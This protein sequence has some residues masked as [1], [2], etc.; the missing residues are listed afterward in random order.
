MTRKKATGCV[1]AGMGR[2]SR[3]TGTSHLMKKGDEGPAT[4]VAV[5]GAQRKEVFPDR[6]LPNK[7]RLPK[8][9]LRD[10]EFL[11]CD[12]KQVNRIVVKRPVSAIECEE[13]SMRSLDSF[14][15]T[16]GRSRV[17]VKYRGTRRQEWYHQVVAT[18]PG[19]TASSASACSTELPDVLNPAGTGVCVEILLRVRI[20]EA[21]G[22]HASL[23]AF[24]NNR[25]IL[26]IK[27][28]GAQVQ[29]LY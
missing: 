10:P 20:V 23:S 29:N 5:P 19:S 16:D 8:D 25:E 15:Q 3:V 14:G 1:T 17:P 18:Y 2:K 28:S 7:S 6:L 4:S 13:P 26:G 27:G 21:D 11:E 24:V 12:K 9:W 22:R